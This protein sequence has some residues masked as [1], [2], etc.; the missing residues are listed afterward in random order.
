MTTPLTKP[1]KR[2]SHETVR[3]RS[4][5]KRI[6]VTIYPAGFIGLRLE[7]NRTEERLPSSFA[8]QHSCLF[9]RRRS[10]YANY[11][12]VW[13]HAHGLPICN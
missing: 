11:V 4:K 10:I 13:S 2:K 1:V 5:L 3:E 8:I 12:G 9:F 7:K 6:I